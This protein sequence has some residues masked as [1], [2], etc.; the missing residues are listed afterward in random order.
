MSAVSP[1]STAT[2][3]RRPLS[4]AVTVPTQAVRPWHTHRVR[5][6]FGIG[7]V[8]AAFIGSG[9]VVHALARH[10]APPTGQAS[11]SGR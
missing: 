10:E 8:T 1:S 3:S 11:S 9:P 5:A 2:R 7:L 6:M 4:A